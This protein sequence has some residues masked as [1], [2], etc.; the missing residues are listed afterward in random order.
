MGWWKWVRR[1]FEV[2]LSKESADG[3]LEEEIRQH[4]EM[5]ARDLTRGGMSPEDARRQAA[6]D[7]GGV[8][9]VKEQVRDVRGARLLDDLVQDTRLALRSLPKQP[10]FLI[11]VLLTL[12]IGIGGNVAMFTILD[13]SLF[14]ALPFP[15]SERLVMPRTTFGGNVN[16]TSSA[17]D[18]FD[19]RDQLESFEAL[20]ASLPFPERG[21][22]TGSGEPERI[23]F[24]YAHGDVFR[25]LA[26]A[27]AMG[28]LFLDEENELDGPPV[29]IISH[30][31]WQRRFGGS[32]DVLGRS[33]TLDGTPHTVVGVMPAGFFYMIDVDAW[34][35]MQRSG[36]MAG[37]RQ[38]HNW[39]LVGRLAPGVT[40]TAAQSEVDILSA[41]LREEYPV[42]NRTKGLLLTPLQDAL[43]ERYRAN[44]VMLMTAV[45]LLLV[46]ACAN[47]AGLLLARGSTR[48]SEMAVRSVMGAGRGRLA[49]QLFTESGI[50]AVGAGLI[51]MFLA[52]WLERGILAFVPLDQLGVEA[53]GVS[54]SAVGFAVI[55]SLSTL[56]L[57]GVVPALRTATSEPA[58]ALRG[59]AR[60][61]G[62]VGGTRF[63][64]GLV[65]GQ[66]TLTVVL[67]V[68]SGLLL[69]SF[70]RLRNVDP[71]FDA[72]QLLTASVSLPSDR[73]GDREMRTAFFT[74]FQER[75][76]AIPGVESVALINRLPIRNPGGNIDV[77]TPETFM[78][79]PEGRSTAYQR[80]VLPGYFE[81]M[82]I[83][84]LAGRDMA[85]TDD[86]MAAPVMII[87]VNMAEQLFPGEDPL[88]RTLALDSGRDEPRVLE[89]IGVVGD[90]TTSRLAGDWGRT[91]YMSYRQ[92][93]GTTMR[94]AIRTRGAPGSVTPAVRDVL[95]E[96]DGDVPLVG[97]RTMDA[98]LSQSVADRRAIM[99]VLG[100]FAVVALLLAAV[101]LYGVMAYQVSR[102]TREIG[103][104][105]ALGATVGGVTGVVLGSGLR[106]VAAGLLLGLPAAF[107]SARLV[108]GMLFGVG[109][110]DPVTFAGVS[111][112]LG[113]VAMVACLVPARRAARTDPTEAFRAD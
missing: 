15:D 66:V 47:V 63:R 21:T 83:P 80:M 95:R 109:T 86:E 108:Q 4:L 64:S 25:A 89:V 85:N 106:L 100:L 59:G 92:G 71:G 107:L 82:G 98:V 55:L 8:E 34:R 29:L 11:A 88:G 69:R 32:S 48:S 103:I 73:Y 97:V 14:G 58:S 43:A 17:P 75:V 36:Y 22:V 52:V 51:G 26:V 62:A 93:G 16:R 12:G 40:P 5:E 50:L 37:A 33:L 67:L 13:G 10:A 105:I 18:Y 31:Y 23:A 35:P 45:A 39:T 79:D 49:R 42:T 110:A 99:A 9:R 78:A 113:G 1:R 101:G 2:L 74:Q 28:R 61:A 68:V 60:L 84:L 24:T 70:V 72:S 87:S 44:L 38:F 104:R 102:R 19:Y 20:G 41:Q 57:F 46:I 94:T 30:G 7:F 56:I 96:L 112:F 65:V 76:Q 54:A 3:E 6:V 91:M 77:S 111:V 53:A 81:S 90:V 27:P